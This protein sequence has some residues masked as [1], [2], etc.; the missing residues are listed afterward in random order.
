LIAKDNRIL[1]CDLLSST[2]SMAFVSAPR[3]RLIMRT[4][5]KALAATALAFGALIAS[6]AWAQSTWAYAGFT[7]NTANANNYGNSWYQT[8]NGTKL[9]VSAY[10]STGSGG[11]FAAASIGNYGSGSGFGVYSANESLTGT[12][13]GASPQ[14]S[15][16]NNGSTDL[17]ALNFTSGS[18]QAKVVLTALTT[19]WH[20]GDSDIS[21]LRWNKP[22]DPTSIIGK[23]ISTLLTDGWALVNNYADMVDDTARATGLATTTANSSSW[24][25][26]SAYNSAWG[27]SVLDATSDYVKVLSSVSATPTGGAVPEPGS[28]ALVGAA[29]M[30]LVAVRR[31]AK[32]R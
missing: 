23:S 32:P 2:A 8:I 16:D 18:N 26:I 6:P 29:L 10:S 1:A 3:K 25:L 9:T 22:T 17:L 14:H 13:T 5:F 30:A 31:T 19:G 11:A 15:M 24:W 12:G 27:G 28:V 21:L 4:S 20:Q 7:Q